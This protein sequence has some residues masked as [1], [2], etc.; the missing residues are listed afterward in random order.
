MIDDAL[1]ATPAP[2]TE[3]IAWFPS[4]RWTGYVAGLMLLS[5]LLTTGSVAAAAAQGAASP[6]DSGKMWSLLPVHRPAPPVVRDAA[7][8]AG[9]ID[10]FILSKLEAVG[11]QPAAQA[12][13]R[14]LI[15]RATFD[16]TGLPPTPAE[17]EAFLAD[18]SPEAFA[19]VVDRLLASP[20]YGERWGRHWLDVVRYADTAG[21]GADYPVREAHQY[22]DWVIA[23]FNSDKPYDLFIREQ[24][25]GDI[26]AAEGPAELYRDRVIATG[27]IS[28]AK[29]FG[30]NANNDDFRHLD[31]ADMIDVLG[32]SVLGLSVGCARCHDHKHDP[33]TM[34]DYYGL[35][36]IFNSTQ[37]TF[38]GGEETKHPERLVPLVPPA[39]QKR[40]A[41]ERNAQLAV[42]D[43]KIS[44]AQAER[45][46][47][48]AQAGSH[49][50]PD[51]AFEL[52][53]I[54]KPPAAPWFTQG[55]NTILAEA[56]SPF[57]NVYPAGTRGVRLGSGANGDGIRQAL[58]VRNA[59]NAK[60]LHLSVDFRNVDAV[61]GDGSYRFYLGQGAVVSMALDFCV[62]SNA[63]LVRNGDKFE[64]VRK[65]ETGKWYNVRVALDLE[66]RTW[67]G[68]VGTSADDLATFEGK[69][70]FPGWNGT[71]DTFFIDGTGHVQ[72]TKPAHDIDNLAIGDKPFEPPG[73]VHA[74]HVVTPE[75]LAAAR[76]KLPEVERTLEALRKERD[77]LAAS[78]VFEVAYAVTEGPSPFNANIQLRGEPHAKGEAVARRFLTALGG[79]VVPAEEKGSGRR[80]LAEWLTRPSNPL[81]ARVMV[82]R[83]WQGHFVHGLVRTASDFGNFGE[84]PSHPELLDWLAARFVEQ[85]WSI[86]RMHREI[87]LSRAYQTSSTSV[88]PDAQ[89]VDPQNRLLSHFPRRR[90]S[91]EEVRDGILA[92]A[93]TLD[94]APG[95][96]HPFPPVAQW[97]YT[98][99]DPFYALYDHNKRSI[100]LMVQRQKRHPFLALFDAPDPNLSVEGRSET[101][102]PKQALYLMNDPFV[103][104]QSAALARRV[105]AMELPDDAARLRA[106]WSL[107]LSREPDDAETTEA[108]DF[109][110]TYGQRLKD[111]GRPDHE[112][113]LGAYSAY[114]RSLLASNAFLYVD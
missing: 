32:R 22:R 13:R 20:H 94:L 51:F 5:L 114:A 80:Q 61:T 105:L 44:A 103:H 96:P 59:Q 36:G 55:P 91:A 50:G 74:A 11:L 82:N 16:L 87:M 86:K 21:D 49:G 29:R 52:Q 69:A 109:L 56:Q 18:Q 8:P 98:I 65:V 85:G 66:K 41:D 27:F 6:A 104:E 113:R 102:T 33:V 101:I 15:R 106:A 10:Q 57:T 89:R 100:Y 26:Y 72:G 112:Q 75:Q 12:D 108:L 19:K 62:S 77:A 81:T 48:L 97:T 84:P 90:L 92:T 31:I 28:I 39:E 1:S 95:G 58:D 70:C 38:P 60:V 76:A 24:I 107:V 79:D 67:S 83:I 78:P 34:A 68:S 25:A 37:Y 73:T 99:H 54:G 35:Y 45:T 93:G 4:R 9:S 30:Y 71:I 3:P 110:K 64:E 7:W 47:L 53:E 43:E 42:I 111:A 23:A 63:F 17:V 46:A 2:P 88:P 14:T 40:L